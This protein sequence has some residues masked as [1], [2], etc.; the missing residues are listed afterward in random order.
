M[1]KISIIIPFYNAENCIEDCIKMALNQTFKDFELIMVNDGS[2]DGGLEV[3][4]YYAQHDPRIIVIDKPNTGAWDTRNKGI[5]I[6]SS[7]YLMFIDCDDLFDNTW[8]ESM[9]RTISQEKTD[10]VVCGHTDMSI[11]SNNAIKYYKIPVERKKI[12]TKEEFLRNIIYLREK[13]VGDTLWNKI[14]KTKIIKEN[15]IKFRPLR[16]G[17][18]VIFNMEYYGYVNSCYILDEA[19]YTYKVEMYNLPW[20]KYSDN[21][22]GLVEDEYRMVKENLIEWRVFEEEA[23]L[24]QANHLMNGF[25]DQLKNLLYSKNKKD[26]EIIEI[27]KQII[28]SESYKEALKYCKFKQPLNQLFVFTIERNQLLLSLHVIRL[29]LLSAKLKQFLVSRFMYSEKIKNI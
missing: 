11:Y 23:K 3:V 6:A 14:Y 20:Q 28:K 24:F 7:E 17:E 12:G 5:E 9:Y 22:Y 8:F 16:R 26:K 15:K 13:G 1:S 10:L 19:H 29:R 2:E 27:M 18:D 21:Y 4:Q 25:M